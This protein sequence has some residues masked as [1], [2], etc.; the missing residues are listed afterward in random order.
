MGRARRA[1]ADRGMTRR[2]D[3]RVTNRSETSGP[4]A[5]EVRVQGTS[6]SGPLPPPEILAKYDAVVPGCADRIVAMAERNQKH[7][8]EMEAVVLPAGIK[9]ERRGQFIGALLYLASLGLGG[10]CIYTGSPITGVTALL[11]VN[12]SFVALYIKSRSSKQDE[13]QRKRP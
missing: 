9:S 2:V 7:R 5:Y 8:H 13:L 3:R 4:P 10:W 6:F 11:G 1:K 12:G